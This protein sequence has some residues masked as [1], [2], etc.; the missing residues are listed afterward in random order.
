MIKISDFIDALQLYPAM[1]KGMMISNMIITAD[2]Q[3]TDIRNQIAKTPEEKRELSDHAQTKRQRVLVHANPDGSETT[4]FVSKLDRKDA[5]RKTR[6]YDNPFYP[7]IGNALLHEMEEY[8][9]QH[10]WAQAEGWEME[11]AGRSSMDKI[12]NGKGGRK[13][14]TMVNREIIKY[15]VMTR[16]AD[17]SHA[18]A[19]FTEPVDVTYEFVYHIGGNNKRIRFNQLGFKGLNQPLKNRFSKFRIKDPFGHD[20]T[21]EN[22]RLSIDITGLDLVEAPEMTLEQDHRKPAPTFDRSVLNQPMKAYAA[23]Q[24]AIIQGAAVYD[25]YRDQITDVQVRDLPSNGTIYTA[26]ATAAPIPVAPLPAA[27]EQP[28]IYTPVAAAP[29]YQ[30][31]AYQQPTYQEPVYQEP[32]YQQPAY[33]QPVAQEPVAQEP[34][35]HAPVSQAAV[36]N[37]QQAAPSESYAEA[38]VPLMSPAGLTPMHVEEQ[39]AYAAA[40]EQPMAYT[41]PA[42]PTYVAPQEV[43]VASLE[44]AIVETATAYAAP[45]VELQPQGLSPQHHD[46]PYDSRPDMPVERNYDARPQHT[47]APLHSQAHADEAMKAAGDIVASGMDDKI[48]PRHERDPNYPF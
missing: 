3:T 42:Q 24:E 40:V 29:V 8:V 2:G 21:F 36:A 26:A 38:S 20:M 45:K 12:R 5:Q 47:Y 32:V 33:Q 35:Y 1:P 46:H 41:Q 25:V 37:Y 13:A 11:E 30:Q 43:H 4:V 27:P 28:I 7:L 34:V 48:S 39:P 22:G 19:V 44:Q 18:Q 6:F 15:N 16:Y 23:K 14:A 10:A 17:G 31:P 9:M